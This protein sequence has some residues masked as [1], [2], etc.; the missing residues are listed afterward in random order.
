VKARNVI[1]NDDKG[2]S[3]KYPISENTDCS[4]KIIICFNNF[5]AKALV[6]F[7]KYLEVNN[8]DKQE[9]DDAGKK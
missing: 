6:F 4:H 7:F 8:R 3:R 9:H 1:G 5:I 2:N